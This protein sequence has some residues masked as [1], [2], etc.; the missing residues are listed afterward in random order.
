MQ[1][2]ILRFLAVFSVFTFIST[3]VIFDVKSAIAAST[4]SSS[5][6]TSSS[7][8]STSSS[9]S[10]HSGGPNALQGTSPSPEAAPATVATADAATLDGVSSE[11]QNAINACADKQCVADALD[12]YAAALQQIAPSL[13]RELRSLPAIVAKTAQRVRAARTVAEA[14]RAVK[15]AIVQVHKIISLLKADDGFTSGEKKREGSLVAQT[16][17]VASGK[18]ERA[19]GL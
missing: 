16:L 10:G 13:P 12:K 5:S 17:Q 8:S 6:S 19:T 3:N 1:P 2:D 11:A 15:S 18:L 9:G 4:S 14:V 7:S